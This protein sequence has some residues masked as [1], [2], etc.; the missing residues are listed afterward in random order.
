MKFKKSSIFILLAISL[1]KLVH[2]ET[3]ET[4]LYSNDIAPEWESITWEDS[5]GASKTF[6]PESSVTLGKASDQATQNYN[7]H[8]TENVKLD[9]LYMEEYANWHFTSNEGVSL[10]IPDGRFSVVGT[11]TL[12]ME[13]VTRLIGLEAHGEIRIIKGGG[14]LAQTY[15]AMGSS[16][17]IESGA[18]TIYDVNLS[19]GAEINIGGDGMLRVGEV[20]LQDASLRAGELSI[21][22]PGDYQQNPALT[23]QSLN[24]DEA[25]QLT[26][27]GGESMRLQ[28]ATLR[29]GEGQATVQ[30]SQLIA[31]NVTMP[32]TS[33][34]LRIVDSVFYSPSTTFNMVDGAKLEISDPGMELMP[35]SIEEEEIT[36]ADGSKQVISVLHVERFNWNQD[37]TRVKGVLSLMIKWGD[38]QS[39]L[40]LEPLCKAHDAKKIVGVSFP[41]IKFKN[42]ELTN[43]SLNIANSKELYTKFLGFGQDAKGNLVIYGQMNAD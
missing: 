27:K 21:Y 16:L 36:L 14:L 1:S 18:S 40:L 6:K 42:N 25:A 10:G 39:D 7:I 38:A 34:V 5:Q 8:F 11:L 37:H 20:R 43:A 17:Y 15:D 28:A 3:P 19:E 30:N 29:I 24:E 2:A 9:G 12:S 13:L 26:A 23:V 33:G 4:D 35:L 41:D 32:W 22:S 31:C